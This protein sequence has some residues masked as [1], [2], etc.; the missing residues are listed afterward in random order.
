[1]QPQLLI[2]FHLRLKGRHPNKLQHTF[3][4]VHI[5]CKDYDFYFL[6]M[7]LFQIMIGW[8]HSSNN[9]LPYC[10]KHS[11]YNQWN[12]V[13]TKWKLRQCMDFSV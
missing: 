1:M 13:P 12:T 4:E 5:L 2:N 3:N 10:E 7:K 9:E 11:N 6:E 8:S